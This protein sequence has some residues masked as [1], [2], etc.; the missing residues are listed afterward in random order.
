VS[1]GLAVRAANL[2]DLSQVVELRLALIREYGNDPLYKRLRDD[3]RQR[4]RELFYSQ[5]MSPSETML[6]AERRERAVGILRCVDSPGSPLL[7]P[8]RYCYVSSVYVV[9][10]ERRRGVLRALV[11]AAER[12][13]EGRGIDEMRLHNASSSSV[14]ADVWSAFGFEIVE[15]VRRRPLHAAHGSPAAPGEHAEVR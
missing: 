14:A 5:L 4:A 10:E 9:P 13:C 6:L 7:L 2:G 3:A 1:D 8:E 15:Q 12:W 11:A